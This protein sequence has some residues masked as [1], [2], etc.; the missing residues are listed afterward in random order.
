MLALRDFL[1]REGIT[2]LYEA[3]YYGPKYFVIYF[4]DPDRIKLEFGVDEK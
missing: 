1:I 2:I 4:E 3:D